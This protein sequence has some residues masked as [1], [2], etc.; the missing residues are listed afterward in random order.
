[1][2][3][4]GNRPEFSHVYGA[5]CQ[6]TLEFQEFLKLLSAGNQAAV[7]ERS[8]GNVKQSSTTAIES[9]TLEQRKVNRPE[10]T[11]TIKAC[12]VDPDKIA[13]RRAQAR[14]R[15]IQPGNR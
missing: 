1:M 3:A 11:S 7:K 9:P 10:T 4:E 5:N 12:L 15:P 2:G 14:P 13:D 6:R 8:N